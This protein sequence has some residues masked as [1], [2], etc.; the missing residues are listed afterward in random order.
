MTVHGERAG[1]LVGCDGARSIVRKRS[2]VDFEGRD[3]RVCALVADVSLA[4]GGPHGW[5]LPAPKGDGMLTVLPLGDGIFRMLAAGPVQSAAGRD[6]PIP[7][8]EIAAALAAESLAL[9][10]R[11]AGLD[12]GDRIPG[13]DLGLLRDGRRHVVDGVPVRPDGFRDQA[14]TLSP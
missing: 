11:V 4:G 6:D 3:G 14:G 1:Y 2:G 9:A 12:H 10:E 5:E 7:D 8:A 13:L